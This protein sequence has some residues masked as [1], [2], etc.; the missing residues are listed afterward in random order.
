SEDYAS[1]KWC[2]NELAKIM[3]C[4]K[5]NKK[6]IAFPIFYHVDPAD[7]RHQRNSYEEAMIAHEKRFGKDSEKI[8]AWTAALSKVA[9][10]KGHHIH[11]GTPYVY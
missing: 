7:V 6:Q 1:S 8:K 4:T 3:E 2:L 9:D 5:T 10:L 11:T